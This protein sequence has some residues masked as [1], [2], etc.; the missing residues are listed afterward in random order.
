MNE[1][2]YKGDTILNA[3][4]IWEMQSVHT[5]NYIGRGS[6]R[7]FPT[8]HFAG[9]GLGWSLLDYEG[10]KVIEHGGGADGMISK[11]MYVPE[12]DFGM[13]V[14]TNNINY[15][16]GAL[17]Y[18]VIEDYFGKPSQDWSTLYYNFFK[19]FQERNLNEK[20]EMEK[21]RFK[22]TNPSL[23]L[24]DYVG[25]YGGELYGNAEIRIEKDHLVLDFLPSDKLIGDLSHWHYD[26]FVIKL[27]NSPT[28]PE[29]KVNFIIGKDGKVEELRVD[30]PNPDFYFTELEFKKINK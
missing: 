9:Y 11:T 10:V 1:G 15:L 26:T 13:V 8:K 19:N 2:I 27:R 30:I 6:S 14:L 7:F 22:N 25:I 20:V 29:G 17:M 12:S 5:P 4:Q 21:K 28:L 23:N 3:D 24:K 16:T 18:Y